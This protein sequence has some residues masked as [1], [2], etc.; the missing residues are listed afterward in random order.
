[1]SFLRHIA[2]LF[3]NFFSI[4]QPSPETMNRAAIFIAVLLVGV[5]AILAAFVTSM[6][7]FLHHSPS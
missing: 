7:H 4:T 5:L 1:M 6:T 2:Q 3:I